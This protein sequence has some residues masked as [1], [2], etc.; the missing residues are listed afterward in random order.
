MLRHL[1]EAQNRL[2]TV[3]PVSRGFTFV[4]LLHFYFWRMAGWET[5]PTASWQLAATGWRFLKNRFYFC[6]H[7]SSRRAAGAR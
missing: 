5:Y 4:A 2:L 1:A 6:A 7:G 3:S